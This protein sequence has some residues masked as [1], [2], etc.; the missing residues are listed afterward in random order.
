MDVSSPPHYR[1]LSRVGPAP[2]SGLE[3]LPAYSRRNTIQAVARREPTEHVF[4]L[5][6]GRGKAWATLKVYSSAKSSKSLPTFFEKENVNCCFE[7]FAEKGDSIQT[8]TA[9]V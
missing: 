2:H 5:T 8:I 9:T 7:L 4:Q 1:R 6:D 3:H